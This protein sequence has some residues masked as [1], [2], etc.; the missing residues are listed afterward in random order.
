MEKKRDG[1]DRGEGSQAC[2]ESIGVLGAQLL[3]NC[4][5]SDTLF[6]F[7]TDMIFF[8]RIKQALASKTTKKNRCERANAYWD[9]G[10]GVPRASSWDINWAYVRGGPLDTVARESS[11]KGH[12]VVDILGIVP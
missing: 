9:A 6:C 10:R 11:L 1:S 7:I 2:W 3:R 5:F 12:R 8:K 4:P